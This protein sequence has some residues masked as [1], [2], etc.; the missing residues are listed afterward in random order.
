[1]SSR[2]NPNS[3]NPNFPL[4]NQ[5]NDS[6]GFREN[7]T[8]I[9]DNFIYLRD[10][11][12]D[13]QSKVVLKAPLTNRSSVDNT[14]TSNLA[15]LVNVGL[16]SDYY[17][18]TTRTG[19]GTLLLD[20][21]ANN[22]YYITT[23]DKINIQIQNWPGVGF[24]GHMRLWFNVTS[25]QHTV[26]FPQSVSLGTTVVQGWSGQT[27]SFRDAGVYCFN[28]YTADA[29]AT[30]LIEDLSR[31]K[32]IE[33]RTPLPG[34]RAGDVR[35][36]TAYDDVFFYVCV[37]NYDG[38]NTIW[39]KASLSPMPNVDVRIV[40]NATSITEG[41]TVGFTLTTTNIPD[42][43]TLYWTT[44]GNVN[45]N[46]FTDRRLDGNV[47]ILNNSAIITRTLNEDM[48]AE[49]AETF[50][51]EIRGVS[52]GI[53]TTSPSVSIQDTSQPA[54]S[55][56]FTANANWTPPTGTVRVVKLVGRGGTGA[57]GGSIAWAPTH[58]PSVTVN[59]IGSGSGTNPNISVPRVQTVLD[60]LKYY[61]TVANIRQP[62]SRVTTIYQTTYNVYPDGTWSKQILNTP[63]EVVGTARVADATDFDYTQVLSSPLSSLATGTQFSITS[64]G[65]ERSYITSPTTGPNASAFGKV[66]PGGSGGVAQTTT[67]VENITVDPSNSYSIVVPTGGNVTVFFK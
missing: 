17:K 36:M 67:Y 61:Q 40:A 33:N 9:R 56:T 54:T 53:K 48:S 41:Q 26:T 66:F 43:T 52:G 15:S 35:G 6:R 24:I 11:L 62:E 34:G 29:G 1:M 2:V 57:P 12:D 58:A 47:T 39:K 13:L 23:A 51:I 3:I 27:L 21:A 5:D 50:S 16:Q 64:T 55:V 63:W 19:A 8:S 65:L 20:Y 46:D 49:N 45:V 60:E 14:F 42:N 37:G 4:P 7:F 31:S 22:N 38:V 28:L 25:S 18:Y 10:E 32:R 59:V 44:S 30:V